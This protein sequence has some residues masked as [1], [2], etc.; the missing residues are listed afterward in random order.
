MAEIEAH[1]LEQAG[2]FVQIDGK[3]LEKGSHEEKRASIADKK[4]HLGGTTAAASKRGSIVT[5]ARTKSSGGLEEIPNNTDGYVQIDGKWHASDSHHARRATADSKSIHLGGTTKEA[6]KRGSI[7][8]PNFAGVTDLGNKVVNG[9]PS[10]TKEAYIQIDGK[11]V[12]PDSYEAKKAAQE[13]KCIHM[14]G[15][16]KEAKRRGSEL[17]AVPA[18]TRGSILQPRKSR[19]ESFIE[20]HPGKN[21]GGYVKIDGKWVEESSHQAKRASIAA[22][23]VTLGGTVKEAAAK[24]ASIAQ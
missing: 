13:E 5:K 10:G 6:A 19:T 17:N 15:T 23:A 24:R 4:I 2:Q 1:G 8:A 20:Q 7:I 16:V 11:W 12:A 9:T 14:G 3:W 18:S 22:G 21:P